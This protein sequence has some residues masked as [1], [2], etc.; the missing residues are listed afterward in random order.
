[1]TRSPTAQQRR[2]RLAAADAPDPGQSPACVAEPEG[3]L[4]EGALRLAQAAGETEVAAAVRASAHALVPGRPVRIASSSLGCW[5]LILTDDTRGP[6]V[7]RI[8]LRT[9]GTLLGELSVLGTEPLPP[10]QVAAVAELA[11]HTALA[12]ARL[13]YGQLI[14]GVTP[15]SSSDVYA[16]CS[17]RDPLTNLAS[18]MLFHDRV[19]H[20]LH[21]RARHL[22]PVAVMVIDLAGAITAVREGMGAPAGDRLLV[23]VA[24]RLQRVVRSADTISR[25]QD[26]QLGA[27][28]DEL[29]SSDDAGL[30]AE[31]LLDALREPF[32]VDEGVP[33]S[34]QAH[35]GIAV[36]SGA[37]E[38]AVE[39]LHKAERAAQVARSRGVGCEARPERSRLHAGAQPVGV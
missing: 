19:E 20:A 29:D 33:V 18:R 14:S 15:S 6:A 28:L 13:E 11:S 27:L 30:V 26:D 10:A 7:L 4:A 2:A 36:N 38:S 9:G 17:F 12:L 37:A 35:V 39:L 24:K 1:M 34:L 3:A 25:F 32:V 23:Q 21:R 31:R 16:A 5:H 22:H 8:P